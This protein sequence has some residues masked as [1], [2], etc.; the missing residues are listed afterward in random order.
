MLAFDKFSIYSQIKVLEGVLIDVRKCL[1]Y[2]EEIYTLEY[3]QDIERDIE[4]VKAF[5]DYEFLYGTEIKNN[6]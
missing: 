2:T 4:K 1:K 5:F 6:N 3:L